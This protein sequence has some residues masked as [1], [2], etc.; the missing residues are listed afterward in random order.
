ML[1]S[2]EGKLNDLVIEGVREKR[3]VKGLRT[4]DEKEH[5]EDVTVISCGGWT[6]GV[7][8]EVDGMLQ[9]TAGSVITFQLPKDRDNLWK[10]VKKLLYSSSTTYLETS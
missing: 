9:T 10:K 4:A 5:L 7:I 3:H 2:K 8:P 6:P 1:G